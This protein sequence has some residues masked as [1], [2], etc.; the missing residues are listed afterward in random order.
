MRHILHSFVPHIFNKKIAESV[1]DELVRYE[2][3]QGRKEHGWVATIVGDGQAI[4][5]NDK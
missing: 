1:T 2:E 4:V 5:G 3:A